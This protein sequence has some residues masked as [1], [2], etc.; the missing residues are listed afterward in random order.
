MKTEKIDKAIEM[1]KKFDQQ[2]MEM[3]MQDINQKKNANYHL[4][5][6]K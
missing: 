5:I 6:S 1:I 2:L 4:Q 3:L